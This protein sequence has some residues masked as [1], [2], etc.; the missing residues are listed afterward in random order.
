NILNALDI[1]DVD[2]LL[3]NGRERRIKTDTLL[4][5]EGTHP[6]SIY[7]VLQGLFGVKNSAVSSTD[8]L[9]MLGPGE[10]LG[11]LSF[12]AKR[13]ASASVFA[14]EGSLLLELPTSMLEAQLEEDPRFAVRFYRALALGNAIRLRNTVKKLGTELNEVEEARQEPP[15]DWELLATAIQHFKELL[16]HTDKAVQQHE[17][18]L[19]EDY[20]ERLDKGLLELTDR[21]EETLGLA[22]K[23]PEQLKE[24]LGRKA[25]IELLPYFLLTDLGERIYTKPRGYAGDFGTIERIYS[26]EP[27]GRGRIGKALDQALHQ[28]PMIQAIRRRRTVLQEALQGMIADHQEKPFLVTKLAAGPADELFQVYAQ[29]NDPSELQTNLLNIDLQAVEYIDQRIQQEG[30]SD[31]CHSINGN[32][33]YLAL[34]RQELA[35]PPQDLIYSLGL[36]DYFNDSFVVQLLDYIYQ[37]LKPGGQIIL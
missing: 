6:D 17:G 24:D 2:W 4:I 28:L 11:E 15:S 26:K 22:S 33:V 14:V 31:V 20:A 29:L 37:N 32:L 10:I 3:M 21:L 13:P 30:L 36:I 9:A 25:K 19:P 27:Q 7:I 5:E 35:L 12:L 1:E 18:R 8:R 34:G 23:L 16:Q